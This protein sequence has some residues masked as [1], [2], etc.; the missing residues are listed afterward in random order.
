MTHRIK[1]HIPVEM[2]S[3][4]IWHI[5]GGKALRM[6]QTNVHQ[7]CLLSSYVLFCL[8]VYDCFPHPMCHIFYIVISTWN[9][10]FYP[11]C[12]KFNCCLPHSDYVPLPDVSYALYCHAHP[13]CVI[14]IRHMG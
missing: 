6:D 11:R 1:E 7:W 14:Y 12:P 13:V 9:L 5:G 10:V 4:G 2:T 8:V 3:S